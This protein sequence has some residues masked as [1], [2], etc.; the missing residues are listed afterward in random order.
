MKSLKFAA[1]LVTMILDGSK[2]CTWRIDDEK[3]LSC[4]DILS[5]QTIEGEEFARAKILWI[6]ETTFGSLTSEDYEGHEA[7]DSL[8]ELYETYMKY[9]NKV[10]DSKYKVKVIRFELINI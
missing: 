5:L 1:P 6:K 8:G 3:N 9:Y 10:V 4:R 7:F 2:Y